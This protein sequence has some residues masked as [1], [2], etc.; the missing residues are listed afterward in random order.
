EPEL[1]EVGK[2]R[3]WQIYPRTYESTLEPN[4]VPV[5]YRYAWDIDSE[6]FMHIHATNPLL[7]I[8]TID[9]AM[10]KF[11]DVSHDGLVAVLKRQ[12]FYFRQNGELVNNF[13]GTEE[14]KWTFETKLV[15]PLYELAHAIYIW[16]ASN[17]R[18]HARLFFNPPYLFE[19]PPEEF[20]DIDYPWQWRLAEL[21]YR[22]RNAPAKK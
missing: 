8:E 3:G 19:I 4:T 18:E 14:Q 6:Y 11:E 17:V 1:V 9:R 13:A 5:I 12:T 16:K 15:E 20:V 22:E 7:S 2:R 10:E 21:Q